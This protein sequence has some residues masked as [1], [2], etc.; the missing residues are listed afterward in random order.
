MS[1][2][3]PLITL[4]SADLVVLEESILQPEAARDECDEKGRGRCRVR[5][6]DSPDPMADW[7]AAKEERKG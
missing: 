1:T 4:K 5:R 6:T 7:H 3:K 2:F